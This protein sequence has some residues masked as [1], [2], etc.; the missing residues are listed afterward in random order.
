[1]AARIDHRFSD[2]DSVYARYSKNAWLNDAPFAGA[3]PLLQKAA[4]RNAYAAPGQSLAVSW[5]RTIS[6][7]L[8]NEM[9]ATVYR[10]AF[11]Q[12]SDP[13]SPREWNSELG[14]PNPMGAKQWPDILSLGSPARC[15]ARISQRR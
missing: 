6:P 13:N 4:N 11:Y 2:R 10:Q 8:F 1:M 9:L 12:S 7:T 5:V 14:L 3:V 15:I